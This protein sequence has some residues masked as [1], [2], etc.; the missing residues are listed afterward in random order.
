MDTL[1]K[2]KLIKE[3]EMYSSL[4]PLEKILYGIE[5]LPRGEPGKIVM[6]EEFFIEWFYFCQEN[7]LD[8][9]KVEGAEVWLDK[10]QPFSSTIILKK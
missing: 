5:S 10:T 7:E 8:Y 6:N 4:N 2:K 1:R 3:M 9:R